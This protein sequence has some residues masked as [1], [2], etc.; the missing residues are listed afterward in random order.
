MKWLEQLQQQFIPL[1]Y[2]NPLIS[3]EFITSEFDSSNE[4][5]IGM[6][7][8]IYSDID[9]KYHTGRIIKRYYDNKLNRWEHLVQFNKGADD[10]NVKKIRWICLDEHA[11]LVGDELIWGRLGNGPW[12]P[13]LRFLRSGAEIIRTKFLSQKSMAE[14]EQ[15]DGVIIYL[16]GSSEAGSGANHIIPNN[17]IIPFSQKVKDFNAGMS[18]RLSGAYALAL[19]ELE[20]R[21]TVRRAYQH[22]SLIASQKDGSVADGLSLDRLK[23]HRDAAAELRSVIAKEKNK[24]NSTNTDDDNNNNILNKANTYRHDLKKD[25]ELEELSSVPLIYRIMKKY[26]KGGNTDKNLLKNIMNE[27]KEKVIVFKSL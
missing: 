17:N 2:W 7:V 9:L 1:K 12:L 24:K 20:E 16:Y 10:R 19:I 22:L 4:T 21:Q 8:R 5:I 14:V 11:C 15:A 23:K 27:M 18:K 6:L 3:H 26:K 13:G 25:I